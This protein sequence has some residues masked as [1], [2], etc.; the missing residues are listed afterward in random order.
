MRIDRGHG[1]GTIEY[2]D[3]G[4]GPWS[5]SST[6]PAPA[7]ASGSCTLPW[8]GRDSASSFPR[9]PGTDGHR[10][11]WAGRPPRPPTPWQGCSRSLAVGRV[12][13]VAV[14]TGAP[15][16]AVLAARHPDLVA[17]LVLESAV[18]RP[19]ST[20]ILAC[21]GLRGRLLRLAA[22]LAPRLAAARML[23][24]TARATPRERLCDEP[25]SRRCAVSS[26]TG[27]RGR[28]RSP[29]VPTRS[30]TPSSPRSGPPRSSST[31]AATGRCPMPTPSAPPPSS[32]EPDSSRGRR[33][34][35]SC[36]SAPAPSRPPSG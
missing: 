6:V 23:A 12:V 31:D 13:V 27:V 11:R 4:R 21:H 29:T 28:G 26:S 20:E 36:G 2:T 25:I 17:G 5:C 1:A 8:P 33:P 16:G 15:T 18:V 7:A 10:W 3:G 34:G 35:I 22:A 19:L 30:M 14:S 9:A 32:P 24:V